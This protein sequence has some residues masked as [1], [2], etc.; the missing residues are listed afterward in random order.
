M[1]SDPN[2]LFGGPG[3]DSLVGD[4][5]NDRLNGCEGYDGGQGGYRDGRIDWIQS[6]AGSTAAYPGSQTDGFRQSV[7]RA[8]RSR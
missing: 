2:E 5:G 3:D 4:Q 1:D 7:P 6:V 8:A